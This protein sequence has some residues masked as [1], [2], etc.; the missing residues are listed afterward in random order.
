VPVL[1]YNADFLLPEA[2]HRAA[3]HPPAEGDFMAGPFR[4]LLH[5]VLPFP[6][7]REEMLQELADRDDVMEG[8]SGY[9]SEMA[10]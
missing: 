3:E 4:W 1:Q 9:G 8:C 6:L 10:E 7:A 2:F 5:R